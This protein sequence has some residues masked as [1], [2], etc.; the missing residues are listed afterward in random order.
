MNFKNAQVGRLIQRR[1]RE[2][3]FAILIA[4]AVIVIFLT[5]RLHAESRMPPCLRY[6]YS[7]KIELDMS[8]L[9]PGIKLIN[10]VGSY[11]GYFLFNESIK[12]LIYKLDGPRYIKLVNKRHYEATGPSLL[13]ENWRQEDADVRIQ[14]STRLNNFVKNQ[15]IPDTELYGSNK[16]PLPKPDDV[17]FEIKANFDGAP[18]LI[19][20][21]M[22]YESKEKDCKP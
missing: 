22:S 21:V 17:R 13:L 14:S 5:Q 20:G 16:S 12:P 1:S 15:K 10:K 6:G 11:D 4:M 18:I 7:E 19:K 3:S 8:L 9:P 2:Q